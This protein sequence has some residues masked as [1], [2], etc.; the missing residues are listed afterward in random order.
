LTE[1][2]G[3]ALAR[4]SDFA[5]DALGRMTSTVV[6]GMATYGQEYDVH[7]LV[8]ETDPEG[9][10]TEHIRDGLGREVERIDAF[11]TPQQQSTT[12]AYDGFGQMT[13][14]TDPLGQVSY[15]MYNNLGQMVR[16]TQPHPAGA[17]QQP[18][19]ETQDEDSAAYAP[20]GWTPTGGDGGY[21][22][23]FKRVGSVS[24]TSTATWT[25]DVS[26][27]PAGTQFQVLATWVPDSSHTPS[28]DFK[29]Y[30]GDAS[31][32]LVNT[33][34]VDQIHLQADATLEETSWESLGVVSVDSGTLTVQLEVQPSTVGLAV[35]DAVRVVEAIPAEYKVYDAMGRVVSTT[36]GLGNTTYYTYDAAGRKTSETDPNGHI[37]NYD[38]DTAGRLIRVT[39][40]AP[41]SNVT[42]YFYDSTG[43]VTEER[44]FLESGAYQ[45][46]TYEYNIEGLP[47]QAVDRSGKYRTFDYD[48][49]YRP[50]HEYSYDSA[51][52]LQN[53]V[54]SSY[55]ILSRLA[56]VADNWS[57]YSYQYDPLDRLAAETVLNPGVP[58][59]TLT[60][61]YD[62]NDLRT[63]LAASIDGTADF[64]NAYTYDDLMRMTDVTQTGTDVAAKHVHFTYNA[65][66]QFEQIDRYAAVQSLP[67]G[68][69]DLSSPSANLVAGSQYTYDD[70]DRL[71]GLL[72]TRDTALP[73]LNE[74]TWT[75]D[76]ANRIV[77][78]TSTDGTVDYDYDARGQLTGADYDYQTDELYDYDENGNR[79]V[80]NGQTYTTTDHNRMSSDGTYDYTYDAEGN[81]TVRTN[82]ATGEVTEYGWGIQNRL[83]RITDRS[84]AAGPVTSEVQYTYDMYGRRIAKHLDDDGDSVVDREEHYVYDGDHIALVF[85]D[86]DGSG[87]QPSALSSRLLHGPAVDQILADEQ[88]STLDPGLS[89]VY[90]PLTDN[91]GTIRDLAYFDAATGIT[92]IANHITYDAFGQ[93]TSETNPAVDH[94][95]VFT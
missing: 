48:E 65:N 25:F 81:R 72:H 1:A 17:G 67:L 21:D 35:A 83:V 54:T 93:I 42:E 19:E 62:G 5:F 18:F 70:S 63:S 77:Q 85:T 57:H 69:A 28:V 47:V 34:S 4:T 24:V 8:S 20:Y 13:S 82:I 50:R 88:L 27:L 7:D 16:S 6:A 37:T 89:T 44:Q 51:G 11:G 64:A 3:T 80:A 55:D 68:A 71:I 36:D 32:T 15:F 45:S 53:T 12:V 2:A 90:W 95:F 39:D 92:D 10:V 22:D 79:E 94:L 14:M 91:L 33:T 43:Q 41:Q 61:G 60:S 49:L 75:F 40:P 31:G 76:A 29:L 52:V 73:A 87:S 38:Y 26:S 78:H 30:D 46:R 66:H 74:Y 56:D 58:T 84:S 59:V 9:V 86:P 23:D